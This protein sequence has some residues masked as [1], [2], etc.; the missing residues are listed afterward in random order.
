MY[1]KVEKP[2]ENKSRAVANSVTQ[3]KNDEQGLGFVDNR[4]DAIVQRKLQDND[5]GLENEANV[6]VIKT[7]S[8][9]QK[10]KQGGMSAEVSQFKGGFVVDMG[11]TNGKNVVAQRSEI[12]QRIIVMADKQVDYGMIVNVYQM[13]VNGI[14]GRVT[15]LSILKK[16]DVTGEQ[17]G[18]EGHGNEN[19]FAGIPARAL[20]EYLLS[21]GVD[22]TN[23][24]IDI[25]GCECG[26]GTYAKE[27]AT[28]MKNSATV[29]AN[30]GLGVVMNDGYTYSKRARTSSEQAEYDGIATDCAGQISAAQEIATE[31]KTKL[32]E[33]VKNVDLPGEA[34]EALIKNIFMKYGGLILG[35][36]NDLFQRLYAHQSKLLADHNNSVSGLDIT[37]RK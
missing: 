2:K 24:V 10:A 28:A 22:D 32:D 23:A 34:S 16:S 1:E 37:E 12:I 29:I 3:E 17:I 9:G 8:I 15:M 31:A 13:L 7:V 25:L 27:F 19:S 11:I 26:K 5:A 33:V 20:A 36:A 30:K 4:P 14:D 6:V 18:L 21:S 35:V